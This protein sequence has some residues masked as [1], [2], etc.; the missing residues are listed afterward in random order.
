MTPRV[1]VIIPHLNQ[2]HALRRCL[3][4]LDAQDLTGLDFDRSAVEVIVVDNGSAALPG[5]IV[6]GHP[7]VIL[8]SEAEAG[9]GPARNRGV[10]AARAPLLLFIDADCRAHSDWIRSAVMM[11]ARADSHGV[12]GGD[13]RIDLTNPVHMTAI[14][15]YESVFAYRQS[16]YI[17][18]DGFSGTGNLAMQRAVYDKVGRFGGIAL[19]EDRDWGQRARAAGHLTAY[20]PEMIV[21][22]PARADFA[23]LAEKWRRHVAHDLA[24]HRSAGRSMLRWHLRALAM[25]ASI[26]VHSLSILRSDRLTGL[27]NRARATMILARIRLFRCAEMWRQARAK[28]SAAAGWNRG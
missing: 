27:A 1:S 23:E 5:D 14:E 25:P 3:A 26:I 6:A 9:P 21:Y 16:L 28:G 20:A 8:L 11:L 12:C 19:A 2:P 7:G 10:D 13:V 24:K 15:A 4:S 18:R 17:A 22:H